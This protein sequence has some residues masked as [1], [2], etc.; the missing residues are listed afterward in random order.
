MNVNFN[1]SSLSLVTGLSGTGETQA[2]GTAAPDKQHSQLPQD[3]VTVSSVGDLVA[4]A[5]NHPEVRADKVAA[6][7]EAIASGTYKIDP[8]AIASAILADQ[9]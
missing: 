1:A 6:I 4:A 9:G 8:H 2:S 7:R 5:L 3:Y